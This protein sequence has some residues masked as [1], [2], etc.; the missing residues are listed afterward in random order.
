[1]VNA[2]CTAALSQAQ[3][4]LAVPIDVL[5]YIDLD[6]NYWDSN[7]TADLTIGNVTY[8]PVGDMNLTFLDYAC[9]LLFNKKLHGDFDFKNP[10]ELVNN[11]EWTFD[12]HLQ[13]ATKVVADLN[14]DGVMEDITNITRFIRLFAG[15]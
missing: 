14:G 11:G 7:L 9:I 8:F 5:T 1:M 12:E 2:R 15:C 10:Y 3:E 6:K 4:G 13:M